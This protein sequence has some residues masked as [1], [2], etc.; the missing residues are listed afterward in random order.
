MATPVK[1]GR[2]PAALPPHTLDGQAQLSGP[3]EVPEDPDHRRQVIL[4]QKRRGGKLPDPPQLATVCEIR[5]VRQPMNGQCRVGPFQLKSD[6][7]A[8][9]SLTLLRGARLAPRGAVAVPE[10][11][12]PVDLKDA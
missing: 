11:H 1:A 3:L 9:S 8:T 6:P 12:F 4:L 10:R 5:V 7:G 2:V